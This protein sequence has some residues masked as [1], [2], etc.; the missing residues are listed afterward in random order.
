MG[1]RSFPLFLVG[2]HCG[3]KKKKTRK[4]RRTGIEQTVKDTSNFSPQRKRR[5]NTLRP[6]QRRRS[7]LTLGIRKSKNYVRFTPPP[8]IS[9]VEN[10]I[11]MY[12]P[13]KRRVLPF[14]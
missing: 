10:N 12:N 9:H 7:F 5:G 13:N 1:Y 6:R 3:K 4:Y 11:E 14:L 8:T 2:F